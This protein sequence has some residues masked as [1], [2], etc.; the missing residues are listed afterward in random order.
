M[1]L[2]IEILSPVH[3]GTGNE[4]TPMDAVL[5]ERGLGLIDEDMLLASLEQSGEWQKFSDVASQD[6]LRG[7][8]STREFLHEFGKKHP[9]I[10]YQ[11]VPVSQELA[12]I[13]VRN[14][15]RLAQNQSRAI[16]DLSIM[17][18]SINPLFGEAILPGSGIKGSFKTC[19]LE[20]AARKRNVRD[21][22]E[23][24]NNIAATAFGVS[25]KMSESVWEDPFHSMKF[26]DFE[27]LETTDSKCERECLIAKN[28]KRFRE[29]IDTG[30]GAI[31]QRME[32]IKPGSRFIG[33]LAVNIESLQKDKPWHQSGI[34][35][36]KMDF[37]LL[38]AICSSHYIP[39]LEFEKVK[40]GAIVKAPDREGFFIKLGQH[41]GA[42]AMTLAGYRKIWNVQHK[43]TMN[44]QSKTWDAADQPMGWCYVSPLKTE[45]YVEFRRKIELRHSDFMQNSAKIKAE[46]KAVMQAAR[47][48]QLLLQEQAEKMKQ[49]AAEEQNRRDSMCQEEKELE[50]FLKGADD[51]KSYNLCHALKNEISP[52]LKKRIAEALRDFWKKT[53]RWK[54]T[55]GSQKERVNLVKS[56]LPQE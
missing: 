29:N 8:L 52:E 56:F 35:F 33:Q 22:R 7:I 39:A 17:Q 12:N 15:G 9:E 16:N 55:K 46:N 49:A 6:G 34:P 41:S 50:A 3:C 10:F 31:P 4:Y 24:D 5:T 19:F 44:A 30:S 51:S 14:I 43:K 48:K 40:F 23:R 2:M 53:E 42:V 1:P 38:N 13:Y 26:S 27:L 47:E 11:F 36:E 54:K 32:V 45:Q 18:T 25:S 20:V 21:I 28:I 37:S